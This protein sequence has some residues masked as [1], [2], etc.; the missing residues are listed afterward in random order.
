MSISHVSVFV[1]VGVC[2][3]YLRIQILFIKK[4]F[5][6]WSISFLYMFC[7]SVFVCFGVFLFCMACGFVYFS[8]MH[9]GR[10]GNLFATGKTGIHG[11]R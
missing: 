1:C 9:A 3:A 8:Y 7:L 2:F 6:C 11:T 5:M 4:R 10:L